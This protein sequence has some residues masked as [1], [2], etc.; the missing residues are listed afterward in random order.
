MSLPA[1]I[2]PQEDSVILAADITPSTQDAADWPQGIRL[3]DLHP[4]EAAVWPAMQVA[5]VA[6][7]QNATAPRSRPAR[8][9]AAAPACRSIELAGAYLP[10]RCK[11]SLGHQLSLSPRGPAG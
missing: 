8:Q 11:K 4:S 7:T 1:G 9:P 2:W 3:T 6:S 5:R 10:A